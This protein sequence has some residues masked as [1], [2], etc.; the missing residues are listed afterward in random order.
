MKEKQNVYI[1]GLSRTGTTSLTEALKDVGYNII[2]YPSKKQLFDPK[3]DGMSDIPAANYYRELDAK[4]PN[5][6]FIYTMRNKDSWLES[7]E[8]HITRKSSDKV[9]PWQRDNRIKL[10]G[11]IDFDKNKYLKT[12]ETHLYE[13]SC[14]FH[15]RVDKILYV[16][17]IDGDQILHA[18]RIALFLGLLPEKNVKIPH[19]NKR[20]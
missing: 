14:H 5:S 3:Y 15:N 2:H 12:F 1:I 10:Y 20:I 13:V 19:L 7:V 6:K 17:I 18:E 16:D 11:C 4:F 9:A 8:R